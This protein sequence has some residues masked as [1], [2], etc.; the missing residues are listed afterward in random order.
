MSAI[1]KT[2][3]ICVGAVALNVNGVLFEHKHNVGTLTKPE[4]VRCPGSLTRPTT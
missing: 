4:I 3:P 1:V 2:C